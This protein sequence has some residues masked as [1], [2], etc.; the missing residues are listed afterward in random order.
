MGIGATGA[1][2][3]NVRHTMDIVDSAI[4]PS[5]GHVQILRLGLA[6]WT[7]QIVIR[8]EAS[9]IIALHAVSCL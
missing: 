3:P 4:G 2:R 8:L 6:D 5:R 9:A 1:T 7:V